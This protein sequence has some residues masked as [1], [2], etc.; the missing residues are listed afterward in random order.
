MIDEVGGSVP[1]LVRQVAV[2]AEQAWKRYA[3]EGAVGPDTPVEIEDALSQIDAERAVEL[4][5]HLA[6]DDLVFPGSRRRDRTHAQRAAVR[7]VRL[8]GYE[9]VWYTN[10]SDQL[11]CHWLSPPVAVERPRTAPGRA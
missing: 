1:D 9:A 5:T 8:L 4:L 2:E 10:I 6:A 7:V 3:L 11:T